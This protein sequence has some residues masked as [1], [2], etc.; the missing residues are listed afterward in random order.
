MVSIPGFDPPS[1]HLKSRGARVE[2]ALNTLNDPE[3]D[4]EKKRIL[5]HQNKLEM[6][7]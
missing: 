6:K 4:I 5:E 3:Y 2:P 7:R 1:L